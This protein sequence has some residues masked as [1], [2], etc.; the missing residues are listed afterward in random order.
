M[1]IHVELCWI[2]LLCP[3][4]CIW[5]QRAD[6]I[7]V[8]FAQINNV[9]QVPFVMHCELYAASLHN[10]HEFFLR[11]I[12]V[13]CS[14][15]CFLYKRSVGSW[16]AAKCSTAHFIQSIFCKSFFPFVGSTQR[17]KTTFFFFMQPRILASCDE[18]F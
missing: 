14:S 9:A 3:D 15:S 7:V 1:F 6:F 2:C 13:S 16:W 4:G 12:S 11:L 17:V 10:L 18:L 5:P 8:I